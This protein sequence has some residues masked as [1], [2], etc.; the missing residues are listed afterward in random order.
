M[1]T[2]RILS[3]D[4]VE[5]ILDR[6]T[7]YRDEHLE[8]IATAR[9]AKRI[10]MAGAVGDPPRGALIVFS[11]AVDREEIEAFAAEDP[12]VRAGLVTGRRIEPWHVITA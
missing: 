4:Y 5:D 9:D 6:R 2:L 7:P 1:A 10:V 8:R 11:E 12:Y 3:Y